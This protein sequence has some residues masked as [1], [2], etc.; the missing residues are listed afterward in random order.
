MMV[1]EGMVA[2]IW[3]V[4]FK[5]ISKDAFPFLIFAGSLAG[6][7]ALLCFVLPESPRYLFG[8]EDFDKCREVLAYIARFNGVKNWEDP[9]F[10]AEDNIFIETED[11]DDPLSPQSPSGTGK[12]VEDPKF[13]HLLDD[14]RQTTKSPNDNRTMKQTEKD[15]KSRYQTTAR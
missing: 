4:Y 3:T 11:L 14:K 10:D 9:H 2:V 8:T 15:R 7:C 5:F 13:D 1:A 6:V 12:Q